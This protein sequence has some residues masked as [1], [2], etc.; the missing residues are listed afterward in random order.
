MLSLAWI[1]VTIFSSLAKFKVCFY[2]TAPTALI[3]FH[4]KRDIEET[5]MLEHQCFIQVYKV[6][7][8]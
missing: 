6:E 5:S 4:H 1:T 8:T 7:T 3:H 2:M